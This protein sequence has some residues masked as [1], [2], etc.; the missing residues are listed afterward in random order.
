[1]RSAM[2][3]AMQTFRSTKESVSNFNNHSKEMKTSL[4]LKGRI[5]L[6]ETLHNYIHRIADS[7]T[8]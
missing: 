6:H 3:E 5:L 1:M 2:V 4:E 8:Y 7:H